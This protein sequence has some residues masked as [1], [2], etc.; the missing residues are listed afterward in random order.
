MQYFQVK[1]RP[2]LLFKVIITELD[3]PAAHI[4]DWSPPRSALHTCRGFTPTIKSASLYITRS[5]WYRNPSGLLE[6]W[7]T[8][9]PYSGYLPTVECQE[10]RRL[11][12]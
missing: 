3:L 7:T 10:T 1:S 11:T 4:A 6:P 2:T 9:E 12:N 8:T 5:T